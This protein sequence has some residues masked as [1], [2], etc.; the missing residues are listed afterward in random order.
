MSMGC[1]CKTCCVAFILLL[2]GAALA[3][4]TPSLLSS[5]HLLIPAAAPLPNQQPIPDA[6]SQQA[7]LNL[8][9]NTFKSDYTDVSPHGRAGLAEKL[10]QQANATNDNP[11]AQFVLLVQCTDA[12]IPAGEAKILTQAIDGLALHFAVDGVAMKKRAYRLIAASCW[13]PAQSEQL[14]DG[15]AAAIDQ[16]IAADEYDNAV[17]LQSTGQAAAYRSGTGRFQPAF[18]IDSL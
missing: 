14:A 3:A 9:Q 12:A 1:W 16:A 15:C 5:H 7:A 17:Q 2:A 4:T 13:T 18:P 8:I 11:T 10:L 6:A